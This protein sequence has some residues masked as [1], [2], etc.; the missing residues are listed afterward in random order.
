MGN[1]HLSHRPTHAR[2]PEGRHKKHD[3]V[4]YYEQPLGFDLV[5]QIRNQSNEYVGGVIALIPWRQIRAALQR[6]DRKP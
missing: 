1:K 2:E 4:W 5:A 6:K 3:G